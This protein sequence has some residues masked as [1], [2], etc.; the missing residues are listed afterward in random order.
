MIKSLLLIIFSV[1][2]FLIPAKGQDEGILISTPEQVRAGNEFL[3][4]VSIPENHME[5]VARLQLELPNG[6]TASAKAT[7][8]AD[9]KFQNQKA[10]FQ[11]LSFPKNQ[12][13]EVKLAVQI[14]PTI[15][16]YFVIKGIANWIISTE[17]LRSNIY[18]KVITVLP[19]ETSEEEL[20]ASNEKT[21]ITFEQFK[22]EGVA[23]IRQVPYEKNGEVIVNVMVSKGDLN[24][25][26]K[27]QETI[28]NGYRVENV[29]SKNAIFVYNDNQ[30]TVKYMWMNMPS[31]SKFVVTYKLI[32]DSKIDDE[33][34]FIIFGTFY[35]AENNTTQTVN[36]QERGIE[37]DLE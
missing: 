9:F 22:S 30:K 29:R 20:Q 11:W 27:I 7:M 36:I 24:K 25:Y 18:P 15:E 12:E 17:P 4:I 32:P 2:L 8:N 16:G 13:V 21:K 31:E 34:P 23:C 26:G 1:L 10:T 5:G 19:G 33:N 3:L 14:A 28:P 37:L 6:F 35:Y